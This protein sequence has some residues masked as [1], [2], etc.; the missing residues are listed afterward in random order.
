MIHQVLKML[1]PFRHL[2]LVSSVMGLVSGLGITGL[3]VVTNQALHVEDHRTP[4]L[5]VF[6]GLCVV[7]LIGDVIAD[8]VLNI[9]GQRLVA[10]LRKSLCARILRAPIAQIEA[11]KAYRLVATLHQDVSTITTLFLNLP[12]V[13]IAIPVIVGC[14]V[15]LAVLSPMLLLVILAV[16]AAGIALHGLA[17]RRAIKSF[18]AA[19]IAVDHLQ[20]HYRAIT[21]GAKELRL[22]T[23]RR[24][25]FFN[26]QLSSTVDDVRNLTIA[27]NNIH[28][29]ADAA[30]SLLFFLLIGMILVLMSSSSATDRTTIG[31]FVLVLLYMRGPIG[32]LVS[33][34]PV[35]SNARV[36][37]AKIKEISEQFVEGE[38]QLGARCPSDHTRAFRTIELRSVCHSHKAGDDS[39]CLGPIDIIINS[40]EILFFTG[41][42]GSGKTTLIKVILGLY[43]PSDGRLLL[44]GEP[45]EGGHLDDYRQLFSAIFTDYY[46]FDELHFRDRTVEQQT[47][48]YLAR[49]G[50]SR[51]VKIENGAFSTTDL[52]TGQRK[53]LAL[54]QAYS[55]GRPI[56]VFDEWAADQEPAFRKAFYTELLP[57]LKRQGKTVIVI[58]HD[59]RYFHLSDRCVKLEAGRVVEEAKHAI[60]PVAKAAT[61]F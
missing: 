17:Q 23:E 51:H 46:L 29:T 33:I 48:Q 9:V 44:D 16:V 56:L 5:I 27:A 3:L 36:S 21:E 26:K 42:N 58:T 55:E 47:H 60:S 53:R 28:A 39:F 59:D 57:E 20:K 37:F 24:R 14:F 41:G 7:V 4:L 19:R 6:F 52:S 8:I 43:T 1:K 45:V 49:L 34:L 40:G 35:L 54:L 11:Q 25:H 31:G 38:T 12:R 32:Q 50:M 61:V 13:F 2:I 15:Y 22:N 30:G 18:R 10:N